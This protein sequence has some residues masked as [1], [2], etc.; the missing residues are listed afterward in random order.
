MP[1]PTMAVT[2]VLEYCQS[3]CYLFW[4]VYCLFPIRDSVK[5]IQQGNLRVGTKCQQ[6]QA[7]LADWNS[8]SILPAKCFGSCALRCLASTVILSITCVGKKASVLSG[9]PDGVISLLIKE[10]AW[11]WFLMCV[12]FLFLWGFR[13]GGL[14]FLPFLLRAGL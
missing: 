9:S 10:R 5:D 12:Q 4:L 7:A 1:L 14:F 11:F 13:I 3:M 2:A 8:P 6:S